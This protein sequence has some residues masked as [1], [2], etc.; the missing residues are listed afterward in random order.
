MTDRNSLL[1]KLKIKNTPQIYKDINIP[2]PEKQ[3]EVILKTKI[4]DKT[5]QNL[6]DKDDFIN[7]IKSNLNTAK[8]QSTPSESIKDKSLKYSSFNPNFKIIRKL[9]R[10]ITLT[11]NQET[12][13]SEDEDE[14]KVPSKTKKQTT[15]KRT[16]TKPIGQIVEGPVSMLK[17]EDV[18]LKGLPKTKQEDI[19]LKSS[20]F[21]LNNR[22]KFIDFITTIFSK[23]EDELKENNSSCSDKNDDKFSLMGHQKLIKDYI[24]KYTPYRG[25]LLFHGLGSGKTCSSIAIAEG[26]KQDKKVMVLTPASLRTNYVEE[27]KK[28]GDD[29]YKKNQFWQFVPSNNDITTI[30]TL[31]NILSLSAD[32]IKEQGGAWLINI[33]KNPN[34]EN[35]NTSEKKSLDSQLNLMIR[36]KYKFISYNGIRNE[37]LDMLSKNN[38]INPFD[39]KV[40]IIDEAHNFVSRIV[41]K[42]D[43]KYDEK[44]TPLSIKLYNYLLDAKNSRV[45][46]LTGTPIINYPN[47]IG[48]LFN[49]IRGKIRT[50]NFKLD[51]KTDKKISKDFFDNIFGVKPSK[52]KFKL[53][54]NNIMDYFEYDSNTTILTITRNPFGFININKNSLYDG[55]KL[56][57]SGNLSDI[58][59]VKIII[60]LLKKYNIE[61]YKNSIKSKSY[62]ALPDKIDDFKSYFIDVNNDFINTNLF[63]KRILGLTSYFRDMQSLMPKYDKETNFHVIKI[64]MS[65]YQFGKYEG[66]RVE[67]RKLEKKNKKKKGGPDDLFDETPSTYR[68]F[69]RAYCNFVFPEKIKRPMP[70]NNLKTKLEKGIEEMKTLNLPVIDE[71]DLDAVSVEEKIDN[72]DGRYDAD[73][74]LKT[75]INYE[76]RIKSALKQL[77]EDKN[78]YLTKTYKE[79]QDEKSQD[80]DK[81]KDKDED[82]DEEEPTGLQKYSPKFLHILENIQDTEHK[83]LHLIYTQFRTLEGIGILKLVLEANGFTQFK[84]A[85]K[86][87][88]WV[89]NISEEN[90]GKPMFALYTGTETVEEKEIIRNVFNGAWKFIPTSLSK[91][92]T[93]ISTNNFYGEII[94]VLLITASGAEGISLKNVRYVHITEPYWHPVRIN[95]V[96]GRAR[97]I[98]SHEDLPEPERTVDVFLYLMTFTKKQMESNDAI[99]LRLKDKSKI[100]NMTPVSSDELLYEISTLKEDL[101]NK[102]LHNVKESSIDCFLH[103]NSDENLKCFTFNTNDPNKYSYNPSFEKEEDDK[104]MAQNQMVVKWKAKVININGIKHAFNKGNNGVYKLQSYLDGAPVQVGVI[105]FNKDKSFK[106]KPF[107]DDYVKN[108]R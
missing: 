70:D 13:D 101:T 82:E 71:D 81:D 32:I 7:K 47:E 49:I 8:K 86:D 37:H 98:C 63:K 65:N 85:L 45:V 46:M 20:S 67:E 104:E 74:D 73:D 50:F 35:L 97:R 60:K 102:I 31:S 33:K 1:D 19:T 83:G 53:S 58:D 107:A 61:V 6:I 26:L 100:D 30:N 87:K 75:N 39:N 56:N 68:I 18:D 88:E 21:Y 41:N 23:Y 108:L 54:K 24:S 90:K 72:I 91:Q 59:F 29:I 27:L 11:E 79:S 84:I 93:N 16:T 15:S 12:S 76:K 28:C 5:N 103:S 25:I 51:I 66:A 77:N 55:V 78:T 57:E 34:F 80:E 52:L 22:A 95:Q 10:T 2:L 64:K 48:I 44:N 4:T 96:I 94:K 14:N 9:N 17:I 89:L 92:L 40:I 62:K 99:E 105:E 38:S 69:S 3:E 106:F 42:I 43:K 36:N